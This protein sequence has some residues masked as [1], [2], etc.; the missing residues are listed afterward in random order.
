[1]L[2]HFGE[3]V[4]KGIPLYL[5]YWEGYY[6]TGCGRHFCIPSPRIWADIIYVHPIY[7]E[8]GHTLFNDEVQ[9]MIGGESL[10]YPWDWDKEGRQL[11]QIA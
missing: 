11:I 1:M 10:H 5:N 3:E 9:R 8:M 4:E 6:Y 7:H 2:N